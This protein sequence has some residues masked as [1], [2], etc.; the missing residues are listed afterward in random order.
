[1]KL[2]YCKLNEEMTKIT[3]KCVWN[4][5]KKRKLHLENIKRVTNSTE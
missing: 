5:S 3:W 4:R 1:M 2:T